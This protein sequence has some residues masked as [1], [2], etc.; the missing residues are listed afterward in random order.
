MH[1]MKKSFSLFALGL[2]LIKLYWIPLNASGVQM[3]KCLHR[4]TL[5]SVL[6]SLCQSLWPFYQL[7]YVKNDSQLGEPLLPLQKI[8]GSIPSIFG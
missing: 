1:D 8:P 7:F 6:A 2:L 3:Q 4:C 5:M